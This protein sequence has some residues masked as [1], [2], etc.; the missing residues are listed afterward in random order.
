MRSSSS[1]SYY[2]CCYYYN[3]YYYYYYHYYYYQTLDAKTRQ[4][5]M[6]DSTPFAAYGLNVS[7]IGYQSLKL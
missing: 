6:L 5:G 2:Y 3:H 1:S 7:A 4:H